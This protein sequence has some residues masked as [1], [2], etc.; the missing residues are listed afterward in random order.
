[1]L[2]L[3]EETQDRFDWSIVTP[4]GHTPLAAAVMSSS[5]E[6]G[7]PAWGSSRVGCERGSRVVER[8]F[9]SGVG[10]FEWNHWCHLWGAYLALELLDFRGDAVCNHFF[11]IVVSFTVLCPPVLAQCPAGRSSSSSLTPTP[12]ST[13]GRRHVT[14]LVVFVVAPAGIG[15]SGDCGRAF[16]LRVCWVSGTRFSYR[17]LDN[18]DG[19]TALPGTRAWVS[20]SMSP[21][22]TRTASQRWP[23]L[24]RRSSMTCTRC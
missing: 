17:G 20:P 8:R 4:R 7:N 2:D 16:H 9:W 12:P 10:L 1:M 3:V 14:A 21:C 5:I 13:S 22:S 23:M 18:A 19:M 24:A 11:F 6:Y 15:F